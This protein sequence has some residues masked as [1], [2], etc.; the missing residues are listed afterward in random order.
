[1]RA[2]CFTVDLDR[3][4]NIPVPGGSAAGSI[5]RG[6]GNS[7]RFG[8]AQ[9]GLDVLLDILKRTGIRATFFAEGRTL[10]SISAGGLSGHEVGVHGYD[11]EDMVSMNENEVRE[12]LGKAVGSV[13][14]VIGTDPMSFRAPYMKMND[15]VLGVLPEF[16]IRYDSSM[17][18]RQES[19]V[20]PFRLP[21]G[22]VE[23]PVSEGLDRSGKKIAA[24]LWPM[25][26]G[27]RLPDDYV[28]M[29]SE[30]KEG[31]YVIA[32]HAW[33]MTESRDR[34]IMTREEAARNAEN[35]RDVVEGIIAM[36]FE[37]MTV[38]EC[39]ERFLP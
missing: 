27:K 20:R 3:D 12:C 19:S 30:V 8:S 10:E 15:V 33:H 29:A 13:R 5:D 36:G 23:V 28:R 17:Y 9:K 37:P 7:P 4:V 18:V 6:N 39:A 31:V 11:H 2:L 1:M 25:H 34:G 26:E 16:G 32:T 35:V 24:Y 21:N 22:I 14:R 38:S